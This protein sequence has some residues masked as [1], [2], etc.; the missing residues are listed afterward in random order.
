MAEQPDINE[1]PNRIALP[2]EGEGWVKLRGEQGW[3]DM[4]GNIWKKDKK[5]KDH[6][7][8]SDSKGNKVREVDFRGV[9]IWPEGPKNKNKR[10]K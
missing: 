7:D 9:Q 4:A 10:P 2:G 1:V 6:W 5:H 3:R 8:V